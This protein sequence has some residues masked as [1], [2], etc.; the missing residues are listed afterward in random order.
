MTLGM[1]SA[2]L[3]EMGAPDWTYIVDNWSAE[4]LQWKIAGYVGL[5]KAKA[6]ATEQQ[7]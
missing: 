4:F 7:S 1:M 6:R 3:D 2:W 5:M